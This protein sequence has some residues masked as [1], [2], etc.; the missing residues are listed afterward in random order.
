MAFY[1]KD[2]ETLLTGENFVHTPTASLTKD[3][4]DDFEYPQDGW[5][6]FDTLDEAMSYL[7]KVDIQVV[8]L[9]PLQ[10]KLQLLNMGLLDEVEAMV[11]TDRRIALYW[12]CALEIQRNHPTLLQMADALGLTDAQLDEMFIEASKLA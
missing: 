12:E 8:S 2:N 4:K 3:T 1:K 5:Y 10:A 11:T 9:T 6:W 7:S